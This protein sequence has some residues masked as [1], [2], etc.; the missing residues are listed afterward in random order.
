[1]GLAAPGEDKWLRSPVSVTR[2]CRF[3]Q[4]LALRELLKPYRYV[5]VLCY[6]DFAAHTHKLAGPLLSSC[7]AED[8]CCQAYK[9][10]SV[11]L[12]L[13]PLL[14]ELAGEF[15]QQAVGSGDSRFI[16]GHIRPMPDDCVTLWQSPKQELSEL[17]LEKSC[18]T[19]T[20]YH[21]FVPNLRSLKKLYN[22]STVFI[23][24]HPIIRPRVFRMLEAGGIRPL[25]IDIPHLNNSLF[26][27]SAAATGTTASELSVRSRFSGVSSPGSPRLRTPMSFSL[28]ALVEEAV[29]AA[30]TVFLGTGES[31]MTGMIVQ[32]R[33]SRGSSPHDVYF[34]S[35]RTNH[36]VMPCRLSDFYALRESRAARTASMT[37]A[38]QSGGL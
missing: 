32:E 5:G 3:D 6:D 30:A 10:R 2:G 16:A 27:E 36:T 37:A 31:S 15:I 23:M 25:Y 35:P 11:T 20:M 33:L 29:A 21:R 34:L 7:G 13:S 14:Y 4:V 24:T 18:R 38:F 1:M 26:T 19:N 9:E 17:E 8:A 22:I 28:L 12:Q